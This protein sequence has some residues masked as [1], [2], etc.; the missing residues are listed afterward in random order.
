MYEH[1][2][3]AFQSVAPIMVYIMLLI[4]VPVMGQMGYFGLSQGHLFEL[5]VIVAALALLAFWQ[6]RENIKRLLSGT[7]RKT[8][9]FKNKK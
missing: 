4:A 5:Y 1:F 7:E 3:F 9:L 6:H 8:Y 2:I